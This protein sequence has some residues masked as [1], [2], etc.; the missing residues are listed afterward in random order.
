MSRWP[1]GVAI[2]TARD[3]GGSDWGMT[4]TAVTLVSVDPPLV[5]ACFALA[6]G[7]TAAFTEADRFA[8][9]LLAAD[10]EDL[11]ER[12]ASGRPDKFVLG[13]FERAESGLAVVAGALAVIECARR[14][15]FPGGDH[16]IVMGEVERARSRPGPA[17]LQRGG[18]LRA[19]GD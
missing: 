12:F 3:D 16:A 10:H 17:L 1:S 9:S 5:L 11:A 4:L 14:D 8:L 13:G 19:V 15:V 7:S 2:A 6:A 18:Q